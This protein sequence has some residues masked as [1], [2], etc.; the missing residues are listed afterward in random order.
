MQI[1]GVRSVLR[2]VFERLRAVTEGLEAGEP[3]PRC[4]ERC[5]EIS[6]ELDSVEVI[7]TKMEARARLL[8]A[9]GR[10]FKDIIVVFSIA[11]TA[12]LVLFPGAVRC[13]GAS[14]FDG[15]DMWLTQKAILVVGGLFALIFASFHALVD[16]AKTVNRR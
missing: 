12:A 13:L 10:F 5:E 2:P 9:W 8:L 3:F 11:A 7:V 4:L 15:A 16:K 6:K 14:S 1:E